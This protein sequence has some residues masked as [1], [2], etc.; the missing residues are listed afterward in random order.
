MATSNAARHA[1]GPN[2]VVVLYTVTLFVS[3][4][5]LFWIQP[6]FGKMVL[7]LL[8]GA[9]AVWNTAMMFFQAA[10][11]AGYAYAHVTTRLL[12]ARRQAALHGVIFLAALLVLPVTVAA[13]LQPPT[14]RNP[15]LW[16]IGLL[17]VSV[18]LPFFVLAATAPMLQRWFAHTDHPD[19]HNPYF[20][21]AASNLGSILALMAFPVLAE[22][23]LR[24]SEQNLLWAVVYGLLGI[25]IVLCAAVMWRHALP[26]AGA[27]G[28][29][30]WS[31]PAARDDG[32]E[33]IGWR[34]RL[35]WVVLAFA[36]SSL[37]LGVTTY[38][39][40]DFAAVPL[41]WVIPL[42]LY[43]LTYV[44]VF[45]RR[46]VVPH[47]AAVRLQPFILLP[48]VMVMLWGAVKPIPVVYS[49]HL[50]AFFFTALVCH[51]EL[52]ARRPSAAHLTEFYLWMSVGGLLGGVF[53]ALVAPVV[54]ESVIEYPLA[55]ALASGLRPF[56]ARARRWSWWDL[57]LPAVLGL[58]LLGVI[59]ATDGRPALLGT[60]GLVAVSVTV[61]TGLYSFRFS[62]LRFGLGV[63]AVLAV[64]LTWAQGGKST[65]V[66]ERNFFGVVEVSHLVERGY[67]MLYHGT[68]V[69]GA[70]SLDPARRLIP[71]TYYFPTGP[72][73]QAMTM[74]DPTLDGARIAATGLGAG[75]VAC[76]ARPGQSWTFYEID[77][78]IERVARDE[79]YFTF[80]G[81]CAPEAEVILGDARLRL[82]EAP[83]RHYRL[84]VLDAFSSDSVAVHLLTRE[85]LQLYLSKLQAGGVL[86]F[87][88]TNS[89]VRLAPVLGNLA[90]DLGLA[91]LHRFDR[92]PTPAERQKFK[93]PSHWAVLARRP[94]DLR[95]LAA[96][97]RWRPL[98]R[99]PEAGAWTDDF[100]NIFSAMI[101]D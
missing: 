34:R 59:E 75:S 91:G 48:L 24:L 1:S 101:V 83:D 61:G 77:P 78:A 46:P 19:A 60:W 16:L 30:A 47:A 26:R 89:Y 10:L 95:D 94:E 11:L 51:G 82:R 45:S 17:S 57:A 66:R 27:G 87:H 62:P 76:Y 69:H 71:L 49:M 4:T 5:L 43:L 32:D 8:G 98:P 41:L 22:P 50:V 37:L 56:V 80:L 38:L 20:L 79:R 84:M 97:P 36:P 92:T 86:I 52:A 58:A 54:F 9:P 39:T 33:V 35:H 29:R 15:I 63:S 93:Y 81:D 23:L 2:A 7:P 28:G 96:D 68:T 74:L 3:A 70:Q 88:I 25:L 65:L 13:D 31:R 12:G 67:H 6:L 99:A 44:I 21:Y 72:L 55:L 73:G 42:A 64:A 14:D 90:A 85:A 40:T 100:S 18:G 53:N